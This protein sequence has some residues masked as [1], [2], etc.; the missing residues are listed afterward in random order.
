MSNSCLFQE[1]EWEVERIKIQTTKSNSWSCLG[2]VC[3]L[4]VVYAARAAVGRQTRSE[5][6]KTEK[7]SGRIL[8]CVLSWS[9]CGIINAKRCRRH[10]RESTSSAN[11]FFFESFIFRRKKAKVSDVTFTLKSTRQQQQKKSCCD[12]DTWLSSSSTSL[13]HM[14]QPIKLS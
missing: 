10:A 11:E 13:S 5:M 3:C 14:K 8:F 12:A 7:K 9:C 4:G 6:E 2:C 1:R